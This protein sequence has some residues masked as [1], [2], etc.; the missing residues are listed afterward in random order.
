M[1]KYIFNTQ[2]TDISPSEFIAKSEF[3]PEDATI[4]EDS[5]GDNIDLSSDS[6]E[7]VILPKPTG[8]KKV[9][10]GAVVLFLAATVAQTIQWLIDSWQQKQWISLAFALICGVVLVL[11]LCTIFKE[12]RELVRLKKRLRLKTKSEQLWLESAGN[13]S[14]NLST[15][16]A[17]EGKKLCLDIAKTLKIEPHS[18]PFLQWQNQLNEGYSAQEVMYLFSQNVLSEWDQKA[19]KLI[20]KNAI[21]SAVIVAMSPLAIVDIFFIAWRNIRLVHQLAA[22]Y[23]IE[24]G[25]ISRLRLLRMVLINMAFAGAT[26]VIQD[27]GMEWLS[28]DLTAKVSA[29]VAQGVGVGL[30]T[31]RLGIK[32][33]ELCRPLAFVK[34]E[35]PRLSHIHQELLSHLKQVVLGRHKV[36]DKQKM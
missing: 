30:L 34:E 18:A 16:Y 1:T 27:M 29:R 11:G 4:T 31:A 17:D 21:E 22:L 13:F 7:P 6:I 24:L 15:Q 36:K 9:L 35:K 3:Q 26:E 20:S 23:G 32:T 5:A 28:Q 12:L 8:W 19:K 2:Q 14:G 25:Y 33:M 10:G